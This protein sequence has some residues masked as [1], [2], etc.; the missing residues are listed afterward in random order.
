MRGSGRVCEREVFIEN[1]HFLL[2]ESGVRVKTEERGEGGVERERRER[3]TPTRVS[4]TR[5]RRAS[6]CTHQWSRFGVS[7]GIIIIH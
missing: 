3:S 2:Y 4:I 6:V 1:R 7:L 5:P